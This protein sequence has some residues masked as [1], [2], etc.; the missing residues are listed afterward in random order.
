[1]TKWT[2]ADVPWEEF[3]PSKVDAE[4]V[5]LVRAASLVE[6]NGDDYATYLCNVFADD[7]EFQSAAKIWGQEE[8]RHGKALARWARMADPSFDFESAFQRFTDGYKL[9]LDADRSVRGS[10]TGEFVARCIVEIG[11]SSFYR[12]LG[13]SI[14]EP[15]LKKICALIAADEV[16]HYKLFRTHMNRYLDQEGVG[17]FRRLLVA[18]SRLKE[19]E[20]DELAYAYYAAN[21]EQE[22]Y[23]R[24]HFANEYMAGVFPRYRIGH[25][26]RGM[27]ML[28]K[29]VGVRHDGWLNRGLSRIAYGFLRYRAWLAKNG[30]MPYAS[31]SGLMESANSVTRS[32]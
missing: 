1:M 17:F 30:G 27:S 7:P 24:Q 11:T 18:L 13:D 16:R 29:A 12:A 10:R 28:L 15:L 32:S 26:Q 31:R 20:D 21:G 14:D 5:K 8:V 19:T 3:D 23:N 4:T 25:V 9:P 22:P 6:H 2:L